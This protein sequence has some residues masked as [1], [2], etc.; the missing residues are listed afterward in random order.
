MARARM[1]VVSVVELRLDPLSQP[2]GSADV[3]NCIGEGVGAEVGV[4]EVLGCEGMSEV[5]VVELEQHWGKEMSRPT[6]WLIWQDQT[7]R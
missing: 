4:E 2:A 6:K 1:M 3:S 5:L 7:H